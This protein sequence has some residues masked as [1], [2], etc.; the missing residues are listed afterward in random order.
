MMIGKSIFGPNYI[1]FT[2]ADFY[3]CDDVSFY[4][5]RRLSQSVINLIQNVQSF[6]HSTKV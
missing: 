1:L 3:N 5:R 4:H 2:I 6:D